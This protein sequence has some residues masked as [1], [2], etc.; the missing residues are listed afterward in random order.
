MIAVKFYENCLIKKPI[1]TKCITSLITFGSGDLIC[2]KLEMKYS[3]REKVDWRRFFVQ[4]SFGFV[5]TPIFHYQFVHLLPYLFP[6]GKF[7]LI[8]AVAFDQTI[9]VLLFTSCFFVY[10]EMA[11]GINIQKAIE[12]SKPK[13]LPTIYD[14]WKVWPFLMAFNFRFVPIRHRVLFSNF[15]GMIWMAYLSYV[16]NIKTKKSL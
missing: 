16:Q 9:N 1:L 12:E 13:I 7:S 11:S 3:K 15:C 2:Q 5:Y 6:P 10:L 4:A 8:K 14:N